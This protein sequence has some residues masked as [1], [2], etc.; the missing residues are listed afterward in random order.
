MWATLPIDNEPPV[1]SELVLIT[2]PSD[3]MIAD[4]L[5]HT[6]DPPPA[7]RTNSCPQFSAPTEGSSRK[8]KHRSSSLTCENN[9]QLLAALHKQR[10]SAEYDEFQP[11]SICNTNINSNVTFSRSRDTTLVNSFSLSE[12]SDFDA[13]TLSATASNNASSTH[14]IAQL[15][16]STDWLQRLPTGDTMWLDEE[17]SFLLF[18]CI[19]ILIARRNYLLKQKNLDEQEISMHFDRYRRQHNAERILHCARTLYGQYIQWVRKKRVIEDLNRIPGSWVFS[20]ASLLLL[21]LLLLFL[22]QC[23]IHLLISVF[24]RLRVHFS[25][26]SG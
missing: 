18:S 20:S 12:I 8:S 21:L 22:W 16:S 15:L 9:E 23:I 11:D 1:L 5:S 25:S 7:R 26:S 24:T 2:S 3:N 17:N 6:P 4:I 13:D 14:S 10:K 19:S